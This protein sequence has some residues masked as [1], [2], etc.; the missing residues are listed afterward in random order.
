MQL[1]ST[2]SY[3]SDKH[4]DVDLEVKIKVILYFN[5]SNSDKSYNLAILCQWQVLTQSY[6][7]R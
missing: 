2:V 1:F 6:L 3:Y 7:K 5:D 4:K